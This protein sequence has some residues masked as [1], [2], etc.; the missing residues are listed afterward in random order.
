MF[1]WPLGAVPVGRSVSYTLNKQ[2][3]FNDTHIPLAKD[4]FN[5]CD[6]RRMWE[7]RKLRPG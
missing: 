7:H 2:I 5:I 4:T 1:V 6:V 3:V